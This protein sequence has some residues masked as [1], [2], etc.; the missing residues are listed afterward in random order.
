VIRVTTAAAVLAMLAGAPRAARAQ[1]QPAPARANIGLF[2]VEP[3]GLDAE[4]A[5][6]LEALFRLELERLAGVPLPSRAQVERVTAGN[7]GLRGCTADPECLSE[8]GKKLGVKQM[9][10]GNLGELGDSY[11]INLKLIDVESKSEVRKVSEPLR[12]SP[13]EL[14]EAVRIAAYE[15]V[16]PERFV[17]AMAILSDVGGGDVYLDGKRVGKTPLAQPITN[18]KVG[19]H[20]VRIARP[21]YTD[22]MTDAEVRFQKTTQVVVRMVAAPDQ[23]RVILPGEKRRPAPR[24]W[25]SSP[26]GY[27]A[28]G[29][30]AVAIGVLAGWVL[31]PDAD[32]VN[33]GKDPAACGL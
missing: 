29:V 27:V 22:F 7:P 10:S 17:G 8:I 5:A 12:G 1:P 23:G 13:D 20:G 11:V 26:W 24:R 14:I 32:V 3:L 6:R 25:Y 21:G 16:A 28:V 19:K 30:G 15:L 2:R 33:C 31:A 18:L 4:R 9:V